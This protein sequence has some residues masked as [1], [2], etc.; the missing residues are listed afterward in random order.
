MWNVKTSM[1]IKTI[2]LPM[3]YDIHAITLAKSGII[4]AGTE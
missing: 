4:M 3:V 1:L 2:F